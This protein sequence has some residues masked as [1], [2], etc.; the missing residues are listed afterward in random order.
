MQDKSL[1]DYILSTPVSKFINHITMDGK[2]VESP[3]LS[4]YYIVIQSHMWLFKETLKVLIYSC[5]RLT[6]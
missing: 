1:F 3:A 2:T 5:T 6:R 4:A